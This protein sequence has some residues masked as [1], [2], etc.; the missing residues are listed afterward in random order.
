[1]KLSVSLSDEDVEFIDQ[2]ATEHAVGSR[3]GVVQH[4]LSMLRAGELGDEYA[5]AWDE[6]SSSDEAVWDST[7]A[8][9]LSA[10]G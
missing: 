7:I 3:S 10:A 2:Y 6:C 1:M 8:D 4:A 9:G 5:A